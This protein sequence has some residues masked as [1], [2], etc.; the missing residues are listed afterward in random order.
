MNEWALLQLQP[1]KTQLRW[2]NALAFF[3]DMGRLPLC[4]MQLSDLQPGCV[5]SLMYIR[6]DIYIYLTLLQVLL[7][8]FSCLSQVLTG[9]P[10]SSQ[11]AKSTSTLNVGR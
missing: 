8:I 6:M 11:L 2:Q 10:Y 5:K 3:F 4:C 9:H 7:A 1:P